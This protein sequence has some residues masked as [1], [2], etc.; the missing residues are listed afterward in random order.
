MR[1]TWLRP[2]RRR[3]MS[4][5]AARPE[6]IYSVERLSREQTHR[7]RWRGCCKGPRDDKTWR[8][9]DSPLA[10][11]RSAS[12]H[13]SQHLSQRQWSSAR[14]RPSPRQ[15]L[16]RLLLRPSRRSANGRLT[17]T[18]KCRAE[19]FEARPRLQGSS[20]HK[21]EKE[22]IKASRVMTARSKP[23]RQLRLTLRAM[24]LGTRARFTAA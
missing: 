6:R 5:L 3:K 20:S 7:R 21:Y 13:P 10:A 8:P 17:A 22:Q 1:S 18:R 19:E 15:H 12:Q 24:P 4:S 16:R 9:V 2:I 14:E 11:L 23:P